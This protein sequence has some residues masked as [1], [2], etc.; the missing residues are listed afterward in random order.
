MSELAEQLSRAQWLGKIPESFW[1]LFPRRRGSR[2]RL[3]V[4]DE[5][6][7]RLLSETDWRDLLELVARAESGQA[8]MLEYGDLTMFDRIR[9]WSALEGGRYVE[10]RINPDPK[11]AARRELL[12]TQYRLTAEGARLVRAGLGRLTDAPPMQSGGFRFYADPKAVS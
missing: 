1:E 6:T 12:R 10:A 3:S 4:F 9:A 5:R 11:K 2:T 8:L 7:L